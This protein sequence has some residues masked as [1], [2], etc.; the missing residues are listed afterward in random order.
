MKLCKNDRM[1]DYH[2]TAPARF[3]I[4]LGLPTTT[5]TITTSYKPKSF[6]LPSTRLYPSRTTSYSLQCHRKRIT[7]QIT[8]KLIPLR[9]FVLLLLNGYNQI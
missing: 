9:N 3:R 2:V 1:I 5:I 8:L 7:L 6:L 4:D